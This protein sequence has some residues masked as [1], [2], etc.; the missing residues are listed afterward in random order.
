MKASRPSRQ[1][2]AAPAAA[3]LLLALALAPVAL[4]TN[5][6]N[7]EGYG[8]IAAAMG[9][10]SMAFDNGTA[11]VINNPAT[12]SLMEVDNQL[13]IALG[14]LGPKITA[15][16][17]TG[18]KAKSQATSFFMPAL[19]YIRRSGPLSYGVGIFGQGGMGCEY[20]KDSWRGLGFG[21]E[22]R[23]EVSIGR[24]IAPIS[25]K[26]SDK[27]SI[28]ATLDYVWVGMDL[29]MAMTGAQFTDLMS[30]HQMGQAS[31]TSVDYAYFNFS[32]NNSFTGEARGY[33][34]AGKVGAVYRPSKG[35]RLGLTYH[36]KTSISDLKAPGNSI[37]FQMN[38]PGMGAMTQTLAGDI[39]VRNFEWPAMV[40]GGIAWEPADGWLVALDLRQVFWASVMKEFNMGFT[41]SSAAANGPFAGQTLDATLTQNWKDQTVVQLGVANRI[42]D[43]LT[44]RAGFNH[45]ADPVP[46]NYLNC[47]FPATVETH[48][49]LG[50]SWSV[51]PRSSIHFS[52]THGFEHT[53]TNGGGVTVSHSQN[54]AQLLFSHSF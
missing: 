14:M 15:T 19:G 25:Y 9:G 18:I 23:T 48:L 40:A 12:L 6:M 44:V 43:A 35:L 54:N 20:D 16:S 49:T 3:S 29:K 46:D 45:G 53:V 1:S 30:T 13:D 21:L 5:G 2:V 24:L 38:V 51:S 4:A 7:M 41:A 36:S 31:G 27:L 47:L 34:F 50:L 28:A 52:Y 26:V 42:T 39:R 33:G 11:A 32:N 37:A 8:P 22:N 17:P 10:A